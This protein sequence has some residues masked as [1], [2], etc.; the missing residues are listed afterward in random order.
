MEVANMM[1][2][3]RVLQDMGWEVSVALKI[4]PEL[5]DWA[6]Q[7]QSWG[8]EV[9]DYSPPLFLSLW[10]RWR[11]RR[12][13]LFWGRLTFNRLIALVRPA[14]VLCY[15]SSLTDCLAHLYYAS[16]H[17]LP[18]VLTVHQV[19]AGRHWDQW[20][21]RQ[22]MRGFSRLLGIQCV[23]RAAAEGFMEAFG[24]FLSP[25]AVP[26]VIYNGVDL[27]RFRP[28]TPAERRN[29]RGRLGIPEESFVIGTVCRLDPMKGVVQ[30]LETFTRVA[31]RNPRLRLVFVG[32]GGLKESIA[33]MA[34]TAG[35][36]DRVQL[37]GHQEDVAP[38]LWA[39]DLFALFSR[40]EGFGVATAEAM[41]IGLPVLATDVAGTRE[42]V[43]HGET[44]ILFPFGDQERA[45]T[46]I[47][48]LVENPDRLQV[49]GDAGRRRV[50]LLYDLR[51][52]NED[53]ARFL[54][55][56]LPLGD[57]HGSGQ[58]ASNPDGK[59]QGQSRGNGLRSRTGN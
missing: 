29:A 55:G 4:W 35:L 47:L 3:M 12:L 45:A 40:V 6:I 30:L 49:M 46:A 15:S 41:A 21:R 54:Q 36:G 25:L 1:W 14:G 42:V 11:I 17:G 28:P 59:V 20:Q 48:D 39:L 44:G 2:D 51:Q 43:T 26:A 57:D 5:R 8:V 16:S 33:E 53:M 23:S 34:A 52:R 24:Q 19:Y 31:R 13:K 32:G 18:S 22:L 9:V 38:Y 7:V 27:D 58:L 56:T 10:D 37:V 50:E